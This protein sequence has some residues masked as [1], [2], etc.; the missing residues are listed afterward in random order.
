MEPHEKTDFG[1]PL[2]LDVSLLDGAEQG[3]NSTWGV[4]EPRRWNF[5]DNRKRQRY[6][7]RGGSSSSTNGL[8]R[9]G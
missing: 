5:T 8:A 1:I 4:V 9:A 3:I 6:C 2:A 7:S